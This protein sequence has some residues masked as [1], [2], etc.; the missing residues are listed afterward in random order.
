MYSTTVDF[1]AELSA[2]T[3]KIFTGEDRGGVYVIE[4]YAIEILSRKLIVMLLLKKLRELGD[5]GEAG[6][7]AVYEI[8]LAGRTPTLEE[9]HAHYPER[10][11]LEN[12]RVVK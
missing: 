8:W 3:C 12:F 2:L 1:L 7:G 4:V 6:V 11:D 9:L 10:D 5:S